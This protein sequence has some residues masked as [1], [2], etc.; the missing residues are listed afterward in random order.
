MYGISWQEL[1]GTLNE[2]GILMYI[3]PDD[4]VFMKFDDCA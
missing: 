1:D 2:V 4:C 3:V